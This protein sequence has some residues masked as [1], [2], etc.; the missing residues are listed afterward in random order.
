MGNHVATQRQ[1]TGIDTPSYISPFPTH[2]SFALTYHNQVTIKSQFP[3]QGKRN[4]NL[5]GQ[6]VFA[7]RNLAFALF[8]KRRRTKQYPSNT[9][10]PSWTQNSRACMQYGLCDLAASRAIRPIISVLDC[11]AYVLR[12]EP[13]GYRTPRGLHVALG[14]A[15]NAST[16]PSLRLLSKSRLD[17]SRG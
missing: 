16:R 15:I 3:Y 11:I 5:H 9:M 14:K 10:P 8:C 12:V 17:G 7:C 2:L 4:Y 1:G 13:S 6:H